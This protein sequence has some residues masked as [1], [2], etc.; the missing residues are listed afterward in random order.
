VFFDI[1]SALGLF[2]VLCLVRMAINYWR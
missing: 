1:L 2:F